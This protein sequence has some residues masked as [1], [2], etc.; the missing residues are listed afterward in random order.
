MNRPGVSEVSRHPGS[1]ALDAVAEC[2]L[3]GFHHLETTALLL[4][5]PMHTD[6]VDHRMPFVEPASH[7]LLRGPGVPQGMQDKLLVADQ[8]QARCLLT[9]SERLD[10]RSAAMLACSMGRNALFE[11]PVG[12]LSGR[13]PSEFEVLVKASKPTDTTNSGPEVHSPFSPVLPRPTFNRESARYR[14]QRKRHSPQSV[15]PLPCESSSR[16]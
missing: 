6:N 12:T 8:F 2:D 16:S 7:R 11:D 5:D 1:L 15:R 9:D 3:P 13:R 14:G 4:A 10:F